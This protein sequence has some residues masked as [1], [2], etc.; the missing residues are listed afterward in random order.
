MVEQLIK[1]RRALHQIPELAFDLPLTS[2]YVYDELMNMGY[3]PIKMAKTGWVVYK[4]GLIED[5]I[6]LRTD[7]DALP[8]FEQ[9]GVS[10]Q[11]KHQGKMHACGHDGHMAMMLG[12][13]KWL[14]QQQDLKKSVVMIFQPAE[15]GPGGAKVMIEEGLFEKF[16]IR[17]VFG[18]HLYPGL[19]EGLYG[20]VD[21]PMLAQNGEFDLEIQ[22]K[23]AHG[24]QPDMGRDAI[25][26]AAE[27]ILSY[28][29]IVSR[30]LSP[31]DPAVVTVGKISGGEARNIIAQ[32]VLISGTMRAFTDDVYQ[33]MKQEM[34]RIDQG[35]EYAYDVIINNTI[36]DYYPAVTNDHEL[37]NQ[38]ISVLPP[39]S[40]QIIKPMTVSEDFA[41]Y[42]QHVPGIFVML[43][44]KN[45]KKGYIHP[46]HSCYFQFDE[47]VLIK[48]VELYQ[49]I[50]SMM[51]N[52]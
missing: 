47:S 10:F 45:E 37:F 33:K 34:R 4:K 49:T 23:S 29:S 38:L 27:L 16:P 3:Q 21:G 48:G 30:R 13:A 36:M 5:A 42:Q 7:M 39:T 51:N 52:K 18:I 25:L 24:A 32:K 50:L 9:T 12:F 44:T 43:G 20:L 31:L 2:Q 1:H 8:V 6:L 14:S 17:A 28:Q 41:F 22:G 11:S 46:L 15:E 35:I 19:E 40:Y 26:A